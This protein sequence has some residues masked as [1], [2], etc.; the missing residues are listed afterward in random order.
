MNILF[1]ALLLTYRE[2][3]IHVLHFPPP[4]FL[5]LENLTEPAFI[6]YLLIIG[7]IGDEQEYR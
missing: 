5:K 6:L 4:Y 3:L 2:T 7:A 1:L